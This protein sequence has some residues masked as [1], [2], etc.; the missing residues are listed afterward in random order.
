MGANYFFD[1]PIRSFPL[2][3]NLPVLGAVDPISLDPEKRIPME[4]TNGGRLKIGLDDN[5][6]L[7]Q[8]AYDY[9]M[10]NPNPSSIVGA[11]TG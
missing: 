7:N 5:E 1:H 4:E 8:R 9:I 3:F 10:S 6:S 2:V 11:I